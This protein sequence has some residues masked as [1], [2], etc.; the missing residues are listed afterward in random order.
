MREYLMLASQP[1]KLELSGKVIPNRIYRSALSEGAARFDAE[2][3]GLLCT[4]VAR[5]RAHVQRW[6]YQCKPR[7]ST[8]TSKQNL[9]KEELG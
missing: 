6:A 4:A 1:L 7:I 5:A 2:D 8:L 3:R 9:L